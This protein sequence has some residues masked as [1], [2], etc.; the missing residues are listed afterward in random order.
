M[1]GCCSKAMSIKF[2]DQDG[3]VD[4]SYLDQNYPVGSKV[5]AIEDTKSPWSSHVLKTTGKYP[6]VSKVVDPQGNHHE[7]C[8]CPCHWR[9]GPSIMC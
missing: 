3:N 1:F 7:Y 4:Q 8:K 2:A 9:G 5:E 6:V